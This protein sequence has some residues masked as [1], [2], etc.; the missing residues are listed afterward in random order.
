MTSRETSEARSPRA[1][2][3]AVGDGDRVE[4]ERRA[5][6][7]ADAGLHAQRERPL[8][9]VARHRLDPVRR[10]A[11]ER[12]REVGVGEP[13]CLQ[14]CAGGRSVWTVGERGAAA[15]GGVGLA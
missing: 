6:C 2:R 8:V 12:T 11:D 14:H 5:T 7:F 10:D 9:E 13:D 1:H 3:D 15:L 4:L